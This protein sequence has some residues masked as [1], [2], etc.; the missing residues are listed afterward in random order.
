MPFLAELPVVLWKFALPVGIVDVFALK[1]QFL[2][3]NFYV[4]CRS[5]Q[6]VF[7][8]FFI[9]VVLITRQAKYI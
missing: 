3:W 8:Y 6:K 2:T 9:I 7:K 5:F 1:V 4:K